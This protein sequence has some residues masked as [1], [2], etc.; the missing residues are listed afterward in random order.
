MGLI[1]PQ[2][3]ATLSIFP[4]WIFFD[5]RRGTG[6][7]YSNNNNNMIC[8]RECLY[9]PNGRGVSLQLHTI[10]Y[11]SSVI[12]FFCSYCYFYYYYYQYYHHHRHYFHSKRPKNNRYNDI[13]P[14]LFIVSDVCS[15]NYIFINAA[16]GSCPRT[17]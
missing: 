5:R 1:I 14:L 4:W 2:Y 7:K 8:R 16:Q 3:T 11:S 10:P 12:S 17:S 13:R 6:I 15:F 9:S